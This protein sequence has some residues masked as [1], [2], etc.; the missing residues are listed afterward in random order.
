MQTF[1][2]VGLFLK[3]LFS[4]SATKVYNYNMKMKNSYELK[5]WL[6]Q[7]QM[8]SFC[9]TLQEEMEVIRPAGAQSESR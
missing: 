6:S 7:P 1:E 5:F 3:I 8:R 9:F 2:R 4:T